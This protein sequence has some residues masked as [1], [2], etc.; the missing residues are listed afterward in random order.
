[1]LPNRAKLTVTDLEDRTTPA[2]SPTDVFAAI[3]QAN[4]AH[5]RLSAVL[6]MKPDLVN[7]YTK[8]YLRNYLPTLTVE[9][10]HADAVLSEYQ[11]DL[12]TEATT[13][14]QLTPY[15]GLIAQA[16][17]KAEVNAVYAVSTTI[18]YAGIPISNVAAPI[19]P[20]API[21]A[22][23][24]P[25]PPAPPPVVIDK[26]TSAGLS[27]TIPDI[28]T[29]DFIT[30][31]SGVQIANVREGQGAPLGA[32]DNFLAYYTGWL[33]DTGVQ[34]DTNRANSSPTP[35]SSV[36]PGFREGV[37]GMKPG[38]IRRI[39]IPSALGYGANG[40]KDQN[41]NQVIPPNADLVFEIKVVLP[42]PG[43]PPTPTPGTATGN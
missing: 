20:D 39:V 23:P 32:N 29:P 36:I 10:Q 3:D 2:V 12:A 33:K 5:D 4:F 21:P 41:G 8:A 42:E 6:A 16:R 22:T 34:F 43:V 26:T 9:S 19:A 13:N 15:V 38:G 25:Q 37:T 31:P 35:F 40:T 7:V 17:Y 11:N 24:I 14:P 18:S 1:M 30:Q 28:T 27:A